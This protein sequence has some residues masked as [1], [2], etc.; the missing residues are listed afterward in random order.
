MINMSQEEY[1]AIRNILLNLGLPA[2]RVGYWYLF[3]AIPCF[4]QNPTQ[5][6][7]KELYPH[8]AR[9]SHCSDW[10][11]IEHTI[12]TAIVHGWE[13]RNQEIWNYYF[14]TAKKCPTIKL[15]L[16]VLAQYL[17]NNPLPFPEGEKSQED[18]PGGS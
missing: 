12:R 9:L 10:R 15:F 16:S 18:V 4:A 8:V 2:H 7:T 13:N 11:N 3:V 14:P 1:A 17:I 5:S 6:L